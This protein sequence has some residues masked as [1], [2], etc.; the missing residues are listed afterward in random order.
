ME[1]ITLLESTFEISIV[2]KE[3]LDEF[4]YFN[5]ISIL[6]LSLGILMVGRCD[7]ESF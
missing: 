1:K 6:S 3:K 7:T 5:I 4:S 2:A